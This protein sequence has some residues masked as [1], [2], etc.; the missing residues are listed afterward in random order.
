MIIVAGGSAS[1][2][3][4]DKLMADVAGR[5]LIAW[6]INTILPL[7]DEC[8]LVTREDQLG[9]LGAMFPDVTMVVGGQ[10]RTESEMAGIRAVS[11]SALIGIH[12]GARPAISPDLITT[13][14]EVAALKGGAIPGIAPDGP[15]IGRG[16]LVEIPRVR[17]VQTPQIFWGP[18]LRSAYRAAA[19][20]GF[21]GDDTADVA[22]NFSYLEISVV[23]G[24]PANV[25]VTLPA[26]LEQVAR[27]LTD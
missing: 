24:D 23:A 3:G 11:N 19:E 6:T 4:S 8:V 26:D 22:H 18:E 1:R 10:S 25:K 17:K 2:F 20:S 27:F 13:L 21:V 5:P 7:V 15:V 16:D 14:F 12:D 9:S